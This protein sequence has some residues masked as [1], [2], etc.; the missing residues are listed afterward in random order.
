[1]ASSTLI[2]NAG[3]DAIALPFPF[4]GVLAQGEGFVVNLPIARVEALLGPLSQTGGFKLTDL[5]NTSGSTDFRQGA[6]IASGVLSMAG[7]FSSP[8]GANTVT[9]DFSVLG[10][11]SVGGG[12]GVAGDSNVGG[13]FN[14]TGDTFVG[15]NI[16]SNAEIASTSN[17]NIGGDCN[18]VGDT[19]IGGDLNV[20]GTINAAGISN[21]SVIG[22][23][24]GTTSSSMTNSLYPYATSAVGTYVA[25]RAG[26]VVGIS[27]MFSQA[28]LNSTFT[29]QVSRNGTV[30]SNCL[31]SIAPSDP[32]T[33]FRFITFA[34]GT[35]TFAAGDLLGLSYT[36]ASVSGTPNAWGTFEI[37]T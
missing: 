12:L 14:V 34:P 32:V 33:N 18:V 22:P 36:S 19:A 31:I 7:S 25:T 11:V 8:S 5:P 29:V 13:D 28:I 24:I 4:C 35:Y 26:S 30:I 6:A 27:V 37:L 17:A 10:D 20:T 3:F 9:G 16:T 2:I 23:F 21:R 1:M 15:G